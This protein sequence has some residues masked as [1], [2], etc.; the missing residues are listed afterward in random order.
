MTY[1]STSIRWPKSCS[2][3]T[4]V[5]SLTS[6]IRPS[7]TCMRQLS[8]SKG[9][10]TS[11]VQDLV[12]WLLARNW[13]CRLK[14]HQTSL[15]CSGHTLEP[16]STWNGPR[17]SNSKLLTRTRRIMKSQQLTSLTQK[18]QRTR[19][20]WPSGSTHEQSFRSTSSS[21]RTKSLTGSITRERTSDAHS[22]NSTIQ[23]V[24]MPFTTS[25]SV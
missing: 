11:A 8:C 2:S 20:F 24:L 15:R 22:C 1:S 9:R 7:L 25:K 19:T 3:A 13:L 4:R 23:A 5:H 12:T 14:R 16:Y 21:K 18:W 17:T 10:I 6:V